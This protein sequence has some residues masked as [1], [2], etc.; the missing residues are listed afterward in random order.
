VGCIERVIYI[1]LSII[2]RVDISV[3]VCIL[4]CEIGACSVGVSL[5]HRWR[6][7]QR[8]LRDWTPAASP[9]DRRR[10]RESRARWLADART[11]SA[12]PAAARAATRVIRPRAMERPPTI[13]NATIKS[14]SQPH[15]T[16]LRMSR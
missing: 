15:P 9:D 6:G 8:P 3:R 2:V 1:R 7:D 14:R 12:T 16:N 10:R 4:S 11:T 5:I 13:R